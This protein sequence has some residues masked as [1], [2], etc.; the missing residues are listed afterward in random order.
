MTRMPRPLWPIAALPWIAFSTGC[1]GIE[2]EQHLA[3]RIERVAVLHPAA[4]LECRPEPP[5][6]PAPRT[7]GEGLA[8]IAELRAAGQ[9]CRA[10]LACI[11]ARQD[12]LPCP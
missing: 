7:M 8:W 3:T 6:P 1:S 10:R 4:L 2:T 5:L 9:D 12:G 11:K